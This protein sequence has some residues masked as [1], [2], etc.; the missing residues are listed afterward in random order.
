[1][2]MEKVGE[3]AFLAV[4]VIAI[5][6]GLL[7]AGGGTITLLLVVLGLI[8]G[9][10]NV[11]EKETTPFLIAAVALV[12]AGTANF[13]AIDQVVNPLGTI[14]NSVLN[15]IATF[16]APAAVLVALKAVYALASRK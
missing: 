15:N 8:V 9:F 12:V 2:K 4:V 5:L 3:L 13:G 7:N 11:S 10:L 16:V 14:I 6:A 1:M